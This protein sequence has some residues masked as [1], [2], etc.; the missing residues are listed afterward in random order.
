M[1]LHHVRYLRLARFSTP[2]VTSAH[3]LDN[4]VKV[5]IANGG[6][7]ALAKGCFGDQGCQAAPLRSNSS[8][9][10]SLSWLTP[11]SPNPDAIGSDPPAVDPRIICSMQC[12]TEAASRRILLGAVRNAIEK[13]LSLGQS[14]RIATD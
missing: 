5:D 13:L 11:R 4:Y 10:V 9:L 12:R 3:I 8:N 14:V 7:T 2:R 6:L 1:A